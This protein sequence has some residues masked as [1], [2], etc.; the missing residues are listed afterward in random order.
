MNE[1]KIRD[2][3][4]TL[5]APARNE[6]P[7]LP[8]GGIDLEI[9]CGVGLHPLQYC[10]KHPE[11]FLI[12]IER[13]SERFSKFERRIGTHNTPEN[14]LAIRDDAISYITHNL[15]LNSVN[16]V[17]LLYPNPYPKTRHLNKRWHAMPFMRQLKSVLRSGGEI[18]LA[19]NEKF[20]ADEA[21]KYMCSYWGFELV[22]DVELAFDFLGRTHFERKYL[23]RKQSCYNLIFRKL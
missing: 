20:Y 21:K 6:A 12:A 15:P 1:L 8:E 13:T 5:V 10:A 23:E 18:V 2:F 7:N 22:E 17:F 3:D 19:T 4:N 14:L 16:R 11:R 9:G